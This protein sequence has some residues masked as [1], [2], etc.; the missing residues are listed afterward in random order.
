MKLCPLSLS[1]MGLALM[2]VSCKGGQ[3]PAMPD[4]TPVGDGLKTLG[5]AVL[6][7]AVV[8]TLGRLIR[9]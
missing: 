6:G 8:L 4:F 2:L 9:L 3:P 7:A 1:V 5:Y